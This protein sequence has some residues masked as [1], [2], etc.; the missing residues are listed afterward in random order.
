MRLERIFYSVLILIAALAAVIN[1]R[2]AALFQMDNDELRGKVEGFEAEAASTARVIEIAH[3]QSDRLRDQ[4]TELMRLRNVV[5]QLN[6]GSEE[7]KALSLE[8]QRLKSA[9]AEA[10]GDPGE[11]PPRSGASQFPRDAWSFAGY[12]SPESTLVSTI[13][14]MKEGNPQTY[15]DSLTPQE[16][17]R[18]ALVWQNKAA[19][20]IVEK[21][22]NDV[23]SI[24]GLRVLE[25]Q[26]LSPTEVVMNVY[27]EG[28][29][30]VEKIRM[31]QVGQDWKFGG[32]IREEG[33]AP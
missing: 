14:A 25:R 20:E 5:T 29:G 28:P 2:R 16:Q 7:A 1:W 32:F 11:K 6:A 24:A 33:Q 15:L 31:N 3:T 21:H 23:S 10:S 4:N 17:E 9:L 30:R 26:D 19:N 22:K 18:T 8:N 13:W 12:G 27:L